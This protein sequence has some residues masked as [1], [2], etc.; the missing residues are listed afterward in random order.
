[1]ADQ[2]TSQAAPSSP[3]S[4]PPKRVRTSSP[5]GTADA[6]ASPQQAAEAQQ[7]GA[8]Q[9]ASATAGQEA[10]AT[11]ASPLE[12]DDVVEAVCSLVGSY[13]FVAH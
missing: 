7:S 10:S 12:E 9:E 1:M 2:A 4:P 11:A 8:G 13:E 6:P 3:T 5:K